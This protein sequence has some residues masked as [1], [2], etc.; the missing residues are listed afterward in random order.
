MRALLRDK[1][2]GALIVLDVVEVRYDKDVLELYLYNSV[3]T[4][5]LVSNIMDSDASFFI[6]EL[7][8]KGMADLTAY[9]AKFMDDE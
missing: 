2:D 1:N 8:K 5:C 3:D 9:P 4:G 6:K 7:F